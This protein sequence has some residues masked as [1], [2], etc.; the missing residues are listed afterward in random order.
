MR[1]DQEA[2]LIGGGDCFSHWHSEDRK[3]TQ[4]LMHGLQNVSKVINISDDTII[5]SGVDVVIVDTTLNDVTVTLPLSRGGREI[6]VVKL[7]I[8]NLLTVNCTGTETIDGRSSVS[9]RTERTS[10][11]F[12]AYDG[13]WV[14]TGGVIWD[15]R[16]H[17]S[18]SS[19]QTQTPV[20]INTPQLLTL[21]RTD[22]SY[23][24]VGVVGDGIHV[25]YYGAYNV[26]FSIQFTN[27][28]TQAHD[29]TVWLRHNGVDVPYTASVIT[30]LGT[31]GGQ[32]G[33]SVLAANFFLKLNP[34]D[35]VELW[36]A[37]NSTQVQVNTLPPITTPFVNPGSP[38]V[39][40]TVDYV[41]SETN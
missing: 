8:P 21:N 29:V 15:K 25:D 24:M 39:V 23:L 31:H 34:Q 16:P 20:T 40:V 22:Y 41:S 9:Y 2:T 17:G 11:T 13:N 18:F 12:K 6:T 38:A 14:V 37:A 36:W 10:R 32:P 30:I 7:G 5:P 35:Y 4:T 1:P 19:T 27:S 3:A 28:D 26:Q 33:Y